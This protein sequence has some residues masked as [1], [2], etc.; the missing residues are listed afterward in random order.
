MGNFIPPDKD[1]RSIDFMANQKISYRDAF[2][3]V[4]E[5][6]HLEPIKQLS[7]VIGFHLLH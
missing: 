7:P 5:G 6:D 4:L 1:K 3:I 2:E